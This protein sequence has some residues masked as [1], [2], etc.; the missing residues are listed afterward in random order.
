MVALFIVIDGAKW[1]VIKNV[2]VALFIVIDG[3]K[4]GVMRT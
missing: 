3:A 4:W 1:V 2:M